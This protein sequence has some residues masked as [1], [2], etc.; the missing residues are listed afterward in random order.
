M[1]R[2]IHF[3]FNT[4]RVKIRVK[5]PYN[6]IGKAPIALYGIINKS[7]YHGVKK[8]MWKKIKGYFI[9]GLLVLFPFV[10]TTFII[11]WLFTKIDS[12]LKGVIS[13]FLEGIGLLTFPGVGFISVIFLIILVG[14]VARN[15]FGKKILA[16][17]DTIVTQIPLINRIYLAI[18]QISKAFLSEKRE[19]FKKA[20][21]IEYPRKGIY[22]I[23]FFTQDTKGEIQ[24]KLPKDVVSVFL[25]TTPNPTSGFLLFVPKSDIINLSMSI[26]EALK[27]VISGG[28]IIPQKSIYKFDKLE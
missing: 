22:S 10:L 20:V 23:V 9:T 12:I 2:I 11:T 19:V 17:G 26:E 7:V 8:S 25:P 27:L 1:N 6:A 5:N 14:V 13:R 4:V 16:L 24:E 15:Y 18:Q 28:A 21:L 3:F